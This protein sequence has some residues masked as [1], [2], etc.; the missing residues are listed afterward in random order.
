[1]SIIERDIFFQLLDQSP[2]S[3]E[4]LHRFAVRNKGLP[5]TTKEERTKRKVITQMTKI[6]ESWGERIRE[7]EKERV[8]QRDLRLGWQSLTTDTQGKRSREW[9]DST[10][11]AFATGQAIHCVAVA[12]THPE[13][14]MG[15]SHRDALTS[16]DRKRFLI[17]SLE[18]PDV[19]GIAQSFWNSVA[20]EEIVPPRRLKR[21]ISLAINE[22]FLQFGRLCQENGSPIPKES[23]KIFLGGIDFLDTDGAR[24]MEVFSL[25]KIQRHPS[26]HDGSLLG[27]ERNLG[28]AIHFGKPFG[29]VYGGPNHPEYSKP[30]FYVLD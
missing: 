25:E 2:L 10:G 16:A 12:I 15:A 1:M 3:I 11:L 29:V 30:A 8:A 9:F 27:Q 13:V 28:L 6:M 17:K 21:V 18:G 14:G 24:E 4:D 26:L 7:I 5:N 19:S 23:V 20:V 22:T